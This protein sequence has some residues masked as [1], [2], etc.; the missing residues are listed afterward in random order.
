[1]TV[2]IYEVDY[3]TGLFVNVDNT[4]CEHLGYSREELIGKPV[5]KVLTEKSIALFQDRIRRALNG[6][7]MNTKMNFT[8]LTKT[9]VEI[10]ITIEAFFEIK[11][12][13]IV[14]AIVAAKARTENGTDT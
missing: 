2:G 1:M 8:A 4:I 11:H 14:G 6:E 9:G 10:P 3:S 7:K 13:T 12:G 5:A